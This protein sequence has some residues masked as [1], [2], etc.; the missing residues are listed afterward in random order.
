MKRWLVLFKKE[1][2]SYLYSPI[3]YVTAAM[4]LVVSGF[5]F[6]NIFAYYSMISFQM[7][8][9][10]QYGSMPDL[11]PTERILRPLY[12]NISLVAIFIVPLLTM[13]LFSEEKRSG[14]AEVLFTHPI[15]DREIVLGK[16]LACLGIYLCIM[17]VTLLYP[18]LV[19]ISGSLEIGPVI[20]VYAGLILLGASFISFGLLASALTEH[21]IV[22]AV[23]TLGGLLLLW[24]LNWASNSAGPALGKVIGEIS[25]FPHIDSFM[26]GVFDTHDI[27]YFLL[28][29]GFCLYLTLQ[30]LASKKWRG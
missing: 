3:A 20:T 9:Q 25:F 12:L 28:F 2:N 24:V 17:G 14:T 4:Y 22:S 15:Q 16:F 7:M 27:L 30:A 18:L 26:K 5:F 10:R 1:M 8:S 21:Q 29:T 19:V 11:N 13:R 23:V 6:Y